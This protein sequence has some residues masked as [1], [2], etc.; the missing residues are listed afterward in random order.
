MTRSL[1][2]L[3]SFFMAYAVSFAYA[4][5]P[6]PKQIG[7]QE[8]VTPVMRQITEF[9]D[10]MLMPIITV[11][12]LFVFALLLIIVVRFNAKS[13]PTPSTTTHNVPLEIIWTIVPV[14][15]LI[16]IAVPSFRLLF[17]EGRHP[18]AELT[19]KV[20][21]YQWY[22]G[23]E[24]VDNGGINFMSYMIKD[25][26]IDKSKNQVR[27]LSTDN[28]VVLPVDTNIVFE[29]TAQDVLH[30]FAVPAFGVK[31]DAVPGR[32]NQSWTRIE[33]PGVYY[34]QCSELCGTRHAFMPIEIHAVSK[35][36]FN[37]WVVEKGGTV[38]AAA[39]EAAPAGEAQAAE[40][41]APP[42][43]DAAAPAAS[44]P[45]PETDTP[46]KKD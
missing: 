10:D 37:K 46:S 28:P 1:V 16:I 41:T 4:D 20:T 2:R 8:P 34:G 39:A 5:Q 29:V 11:I 24:Y 25:E 17:L 43:E 19:V 30:S 7:L 6:H 45:T 26:E 38:K 35:E 40:A 22:W 44:E 27:L 31:V 36:D 14:I 23:Y 12:T 42:K 15:I 21:G 3:F 32:L 13:N 33:K 18:E 9:H